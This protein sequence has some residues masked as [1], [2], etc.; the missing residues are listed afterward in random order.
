MR[1]CDCNQ[2]FDCSVIAIMASIIIAIVGAIL[3]FTATITLS[4]LFIW[5]GLAIAVIFLIA[6]LVLSASACVLRRCTNEV[7]PITLFGILLTLLTAVVLLVVNL[8]A[9]SILFA[10]VNGAFLG[11]LALIFTTVSC[12]VRCAAQNSY[13]ED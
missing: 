6:L 12:I 5:I 11:G 2:R 10:L 7:L 13:C 4:T 3:T 9:T 8:A 1:N